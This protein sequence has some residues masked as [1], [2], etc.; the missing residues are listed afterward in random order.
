MRARCA[1]ATTRERRAPARS[2]ARA[3]VSSLRALFRDRRARLRRGKRRVRR[4]EQ[5]ARRVSPLAFR[6]DSSICDRFERNTVIRSTTGAK[7]ETRRRFYA[8]PRLRS[9][10]SVSRSLER[11]KARVVQRF[12]HREPSL[13]VPRREAFDERP[14][15]GGV[16]EREVAALGSRT[17]RPR[18]QHGSILCRRRRRRRRVGPF[19]RSFKRSSAASI[20]HLARAIASAGYSAGVATRRSVNPI[21]NASNLGHGAI[22]P[23]WL[24]RRARA[25]GRQRRRARGRTRPRARRA[26]LMNVRFFYLVAD[27]LLGR[28]ARRI[29]DGLGRVELTLAAR[30]AAPPK[31]TNRTPRVSRKPKRSPA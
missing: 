23:R 30:S 18:V 6:E 14:R 27:H 13:R 15:L 5:C 12:T 1:R 19:R 29:E 10:Y 21:A 9:R 2:D 11:L 26:S 25:R 8:R 22:P 24:P 16:D 31:S 17:R 4:G 3:S 7:D 20:A 28:A